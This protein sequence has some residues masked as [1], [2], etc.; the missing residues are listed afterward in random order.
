[1]NRRERRAAVA[2][3]KTA[4]GVAPGYVADL[5]TQ[6]RE[7]FRQGRAAQAEA[8]CKQILERY[9]ADKTG[10]NLLG[11]VYQAAGRHRLAVKMFAKAIAADDLDAACH[12]NI[13]CSYQVMD[14]P[15]AAAAHFRKALAL[16][17]NG[18]EP[19]DFFC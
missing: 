4:A 1:M 7:A 13:A 17:L 8:A 6:A 15:E 16:G 18:Q 11:V 10:L 12:Y 5:L 19:E 2:R 9:P 14:Q 3:A